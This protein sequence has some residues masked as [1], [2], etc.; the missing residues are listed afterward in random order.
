MSALQ[1][2]AAMF[3]AHPSHRRPVHASMLQRSRPRTSTWA[4]IGSTLPNE[5][6]DLYTYHI[7]HH[8]LAELQG[9]YLQ[10]AQGG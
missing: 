5:R 4:P 9:V 8:P 1:L 3:V 2:P 7:F 6:H 10:S